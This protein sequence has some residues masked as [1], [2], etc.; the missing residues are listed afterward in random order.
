MDLH[1]QCKEIINESWDSCFEGSP[2]YD[3]VCK[4]KIASSFFRKWNKD[5]FGDLHKRKL[6][7]ENALMIAQ[8]EL[9]SQP[10]D[11]E[12]ATKANLELL[13]K[14]KPNSLTTKSKSTMV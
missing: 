7:L 5:V 8:F 12:K 10:F 14:Q 9:S 11:K 1:P 3:L 6:E 2:S 4:I 13:E